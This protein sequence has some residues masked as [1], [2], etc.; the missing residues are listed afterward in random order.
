MKEPGVTLASKL[1]KGA[2]ILSLA[3]ILTKLLGTLQKIPLQNIGGDGVLAFT[4][5]CVLFIR[6][7]LR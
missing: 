4:I 3:A 6:C 7:S 5:R 2:A 1:L